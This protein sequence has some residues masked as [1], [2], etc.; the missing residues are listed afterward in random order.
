MNT[1]ILI[2]THGIFADGIYESLKIV[3]GEQSNIERLNAYVNN[4]IDYSK[5][6]KDIV[7]KHDYKKSNLLVITDLFGGS[8]NNE[9]LKYVANYPFYL[10]SGLNFGLLLELVTSAKE[11]NK[12]TIL[13]IIQHSK[14]NI[15]LC[16]DIL[17]LNE[18]SD[19]DF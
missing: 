18:L 2:A 5:L 19:S 15:V 4:N 6:I 3:V 14:E 16:N 9:F 7:T 8:V 12:K 1:K 17:H 11:L 10:I 13:E